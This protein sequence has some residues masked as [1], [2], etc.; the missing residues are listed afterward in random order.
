MALSDFN[1]SQPQGQLIT[2]VSETVVPTAAGAVS[3]AFKAFLYTE[4]VFYLKNTSDRAVNVQV[5]GSPTE[6][7]TD[8]YDLGSPVALAVGSVTPQLDKVIQSDYH[9][10]IRIKVTSTTTD[11]TVGSVSV[12]V[13]A[14]A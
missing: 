13:G 14:I 12:V 5:Q 4:K 9:M 3:S 1:P 7:F 6:D 11:A 8:A 2:T 10:Y